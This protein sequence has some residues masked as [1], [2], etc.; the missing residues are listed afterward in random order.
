M[1]SIERV[2]RLVIEVWHWIT[3]V[4]LVASIGLNH[5]GGLQRIFSVNVSCFSSVNC[6]EIHVIFD[7]DT[8]R[9][10]GYKFSEMSDID[11]DNHTF[12]MRDF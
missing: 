10:Q 3:K 6:A 1:T 7:I 5:Q 9:I 2:V 11:K 4:V 12:Q 8:L